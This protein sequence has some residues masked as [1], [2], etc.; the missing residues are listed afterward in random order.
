LIVK[1][2][3]LIVSLIL[4]TLV[5]GIER[6]EATQKRVETESSNEATR[7]AVEEV[8]AAIQGRLE[9][10]ARN[11]IAAW[12]NF[13]AEDMIAP[14]EG[15]LP[16]KQA[17][18]AGRKS[19]PREVH[20]FYGPLED[21]RVRVHG[22]AAVAT[23]RV[24]QYNEIGGQTTF[25]Q[26][27]QIETHV[28]QQGR[29]LL[30]GVADSALPLEP[31]ATTIDF[32]VYDGYIGKY[33]WASTLISKVTRDGDHLMLELAGD[34]SELLPESEM[35]FFV[36]GGAARGDTGRYVFVKDAGGRVTHYIYREYGATDRIVKRVE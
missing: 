10:L 32:R 35:T 28:R 17:W 29:W 7:R 30:A 11:D 16:S 21:V 2:T 19:F 14:L 20:Y 36:K 18:I 6:P 9:A 26:S 31:S 3:G 13:V 27:W 34:K 25:F 8:K 12:A 24:K 33:A 1:S 15:Q 5:A 23:Y 22:D 4:Y